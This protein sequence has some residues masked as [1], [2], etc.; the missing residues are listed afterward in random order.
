MWNLAAGIGCE[1]TAQVVCSGTHSHPISYRYSSLLPIRFAKSTS[2]VPV[3]QFRRPETCQI[4]VHLELEMDRSE[5]ETEHFGFETS[6][7][8]AWMPC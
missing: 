4:D 8:K 7:S 3:S 5:L 2:Y 1:Q 6:Q